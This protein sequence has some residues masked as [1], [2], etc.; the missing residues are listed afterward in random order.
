MNQ[1]LLANKALR[2]ALFFSAVVCCAIACNMSPARATGIGIQPANIELVVQPGSSIRRSIR[3][4]NLRTD[5]PQ[6]FIVGVADWTLDDNGQLKLLPPSVSS[7]GGWVR[8]AP[9]SFTLKP[10]EAQ[11]IVV[12]IAVPAKLPEMREYHMAILVTNPVPGVEEMKKLNG[13]WNQVQ[14]ASLFYLTP[15]GAKPEPRAEQGALDA[16]GAGFVRTNIAN[17]GQA[18]ARLIA[19]FQV[20]NAAGGEV[21]GGEAQ[22]VLL[23][24]QKREWRGSLNAGKLEPGRYTVNWKLYTVFDPDRPNE[25]FG[26]L[27]QEQTWPW[28]KT[29]ASEAAVAP[30]KP[31]GKSSR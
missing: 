31:A 27:L 30:A 19:K 9:A 7:A 22:S 8:Y 21:H 4:A 10:A 6:Q 24:G 18:H 16:A 29:S 20:T 1:P 11:D 15:P 5:K 23:P 25:R 17:S 13:V 12:D 28:N 3:V 2:G 26:E 14:V